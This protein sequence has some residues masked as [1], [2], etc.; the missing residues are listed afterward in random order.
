MTTDT[1]VQDQ[2]KR[3][4]DAL[5]RRFALAEAEVRQQQ[6]KNKKRPYEE[7]DRTKHDVN[8]PSVHPAH[9]SVMPSSNTSFKKGYLFKKPLL[10]MLC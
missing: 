3:T 6:Q 9:A 4:L 5:E 1:M 7:K 8:S 2:K 10:V